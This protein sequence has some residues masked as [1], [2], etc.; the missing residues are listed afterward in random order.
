MILNGS[1][2]TLTREFADV[3]GIILKDI[4]RVAHRHRKE[5]AKDTEARTAMP[6]VAC[7]MLADTLSEMV[8]LT[9]VTHAKVAG[10]L[11]EG[12]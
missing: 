8:A 10:P 9:A 5:A 1:N 11:A 3:E 6:S 7:L 2:L 12:L 4:H